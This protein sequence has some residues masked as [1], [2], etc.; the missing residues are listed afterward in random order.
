MAAMGSDRAYVILD[1]L[2]ETE[3]A[4][5]PEQMEKMQLWVDGLTTEEWTETLYTTWLYTFEPLLAEPG[6]GYPQFMQSEAWLDK[7]LNTSLGSWAELKHD[8]ILYAKQVYAELGG[9]G[10]AP[11]PL[12]ARGYVEPVPEFYA[13]LEALTTMTLEGLQ[14]RSLLSEQDLNS[15]MRL[16]SLAAALQVMAEKEL[17]GE[18]LTEEEHH[19]IRFYGGE[20]EHLTMAAAD[21]EDEDPAAQPV[22]DEEP[23]AAV[24]ADVATAPDP[25]QDGNPNPVVLEEA[26][27]RINEIYA[28]VPL[29]N[30]DGTIQLQ[31]AK[32]GVFSY[33]EFTWP[34]EDRLTDEKWRTM[35]DEGEAPPLPEWT[36]SFFTNA[37]EYA[38]FQQTIYNLQRAISQAY[39]YLD[40]GTFYGVSETVAAQFAAEFDALREAKQ[41]MGRQWIHA[42]YRSFD[43]QAEDLV[44]VAVR[45]TW[46]DRLYAF[47]EMPGDAEPLS[48]PVGQRGP[49]TLD[50]T[51][52][53]ERVFEQWLV[54]NVVYN[55]EPPTWEE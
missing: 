31:V 8:T 49:Y 19:L 27:G 36:D 39:W 21:R 30:E 32:G 52:T 12:P 41:F 50:V 53:L 51:Y 34:A 5:Y 9:G 17:R 44:V 40:A 23:Q 11:Q 43:I 13:R 15:L 48:D 22:M 24:I 14:E 42:S 29:I 55:N 28:V 4:N 46:E 10:G 6:D 2:G 35:L 45:E 54:T 16:Q 33:Y 47:Q 18:P 25:D 3:Y 26:V 37:T 38:A 20:L 1:E 7:Q